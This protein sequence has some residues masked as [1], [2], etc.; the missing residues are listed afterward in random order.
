MDQ[1]FQVVGA[2][3]V[4]VAFAGLQAGRMR[5]RSRMYLLLNLVGSIV[6]TG[7]AIHGRDWGFLLLEA[8]WAVVSAWGLAQVLRD[9]QASPAS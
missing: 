9:G 3:L 6:L 2:V 8:V 4:L 1:V 7:V 5:A